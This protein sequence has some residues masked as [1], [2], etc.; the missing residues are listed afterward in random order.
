VKGV[1]LEN[2]NWIEAQGFLDTETVVVIPLGAA[3]KEHGPHLKLNNDWLIAEYL[4]QQVAERIDVVVAPTVPYYY[5]PAFTEY[6]GSTTLGI[7]TARDLIIDICRSLATHG[8]HRFY[9]LNTGIST[10]QPLQAAAETLRRENIVL[11][12]SNNARI[13]KAVVGEIGE[14]E[15]GSHADEIETSMMLCIAPETV[16]MQQ[17]PNDYH[18]SSEGGLTRDPAGQGVYSPTGVFGDATLATAPKGEVL[19]RAL[20]NGIVSDIEALRSSR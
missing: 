17:A 4:K 6:P 9:V 11:R 3:A 2:L 1:F 20:V 12:F 15:G 13:L 8:P 19:V 14:Q 10:I 5:Y 18:P 16:D 7:E